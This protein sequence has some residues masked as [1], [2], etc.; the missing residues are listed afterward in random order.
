MLTLFAFSSENWQR[1]SE[2]VDHLMNLF[3]Q[4]LRQETENLHKNN[5]HLLVIGDCSRFRWEFRAANR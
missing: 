1:P 5:I 3:L 2:E 4:T